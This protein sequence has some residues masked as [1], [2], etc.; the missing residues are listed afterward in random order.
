MISSVRI[1]GYKA[2][3]DTT[4]ALGRLTV[5]V[6]PNGAGKTSVLE[7]LRAIA[8]SEATGMCFPGDIAPE[9]MRHQGGA[10]RIEFA[11]AGETEGHPGS[12][13]L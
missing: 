13:R 5:L 8:R 9:D 7:A 3:R 1:Q 6:G 4:V 2:H 12:S 11:A 10:D